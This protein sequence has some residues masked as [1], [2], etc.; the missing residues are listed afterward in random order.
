MS[1]TLTFR[2]EDD[3][4]TRHVVRH[5]TVWIGSRVW[6]NFGRAII[7]QRGFDMF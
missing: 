3:P 4:E 7:L 5:S 2:K 6:Q 1:C